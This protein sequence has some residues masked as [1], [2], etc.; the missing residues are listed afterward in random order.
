MLECVNISLIEMSY[1]EFE[2]KLSEKISLDVR[3][4]VYWELFDLNIIV[5]MEVIKTQ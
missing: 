3:E 2:G 1:S 4:G 5:A